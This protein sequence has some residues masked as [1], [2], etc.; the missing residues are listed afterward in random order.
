MSAIG[1][2]DDTPRDYM[3][4]DIPEDEI[5]CLSHD[6][7]IALAYME[8]DRRRHIRFVHPRCYNEVP[9]QLERD[10][11]RERRRPINMS[12]LDKMAADIS[13]RDFLTWCNKKDDFCHLQQ[14]TQYPIR[15]QAATLRM[16]LSLKMLQTVEMI[17]RYVRKKRS[18]ALDRV[19]FEEYRQDHSATFDEFYIGLQR[20][21]RRV[22][23][24]CHTF[25]ICDQD[26]RK[27]LLAITPFPSLQTAIDLC[28]SEEAACKNESL[29]SRFG[30][31]S[32]NGIQKRPQMWKLWSS[33][34]DS[35][36][37]CP[38]K[39]RE[40]H[41]CGK[42]GQFSTVGEKHEAK[43]KKLDARSKRLVS[44][45]LA[46]VAATRPA[47]TIP[48]DI[49]N[50]SGER[51]Y[52]VNAI[53]DTGAEATVV[54][55]AIL[56]LLGKDINNLLQHGVDNLTA[57]NNSSLN[58]AG[59]LELQLRYTGRSVTTSILF[60]PEHDGMLLSWFICVELGLLPPYYPEPS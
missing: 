35:G 12:C 13:Y 18:V 10:C 7:L 50:R 49:N 45:R 17:Q 60:S 3:T 58:C 20:I 23:P 44:V 6:Q 36:K 11:D 55:V 21:V 48:I 53:P 1:S 32:V 25:C 34:H 22:M 40:C 27:K 4:I 26:G 41:N 28:C 31:T 29:L 37:D 2:V 24:T 16:T 33:P 38:T 51:L 19:E 47:P 54:S 56:Q 5:Q 15:E 8:E 59:R 46:H 30:A 14:I 9:E 39:G 57:A 43:G 52:T 42:P